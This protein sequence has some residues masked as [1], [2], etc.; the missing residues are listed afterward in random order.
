[1][2]LVEQTTKITLAW[3]LFNQQTPKVHIAEHLGIHR[4]TVYRWIKSIQ[5]AGSLEVFIDRY[6]L[7]KKGP[8]KKRKADGLVKLWIWQIRKDKKDCCGQKIKYFLKRDYGL[9]LSVTKIY[10]ILRE[11]YILRSKWK[12]NQKKGP[13]P[14]ATKPREVIQM[15]TMDFGGIFAFNAIDIFS[16]EADVILRPSLTSHDGYIFLRTSMKRRFNGHIGLAQTDNEPEY[17]GEFKK[18]VLEY[19]D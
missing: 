12:K 11:K 17:K 10:D 9:D 6:L 7:A 15:D 5:E 16:K 18:H 13:V 1:M 19:A 3:E 14:Q 8:R 2:E 4:R